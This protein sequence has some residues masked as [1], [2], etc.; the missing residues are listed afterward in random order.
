VKLSQAKSIAKDCGLRF[1]SKVY[2][3]VRLH[4]M[5]LFAYDDIQYEMQELS[6]DIMKLVKENGV[7]TESIRNWMEK[8]G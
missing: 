3:N 8:R 1:L 5:N 6:D 7:E 4:A 2:D